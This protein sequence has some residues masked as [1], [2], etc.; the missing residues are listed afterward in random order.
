MQAEEKEE[1]I[2]NSLKNE[3]ETQVALQPHCL[4]CSKSPVET[5]KTERK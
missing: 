3:N 4:M 5:S 1:M 2:S